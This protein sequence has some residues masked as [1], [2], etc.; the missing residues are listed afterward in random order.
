MNI[1]Q[2][3]QITPTTYFKNSQRN[4]T[5][6]N[7]KCNKNISIDEAVKLTTVDQKEVVE[8]IFKLVNKIKFLNKILG[9]NDKITKPVTVMLG[10]AKVSLM[11]D[12]SNTGKIKINLC[13]DTNAAI[14]E[15]VSPQRGYISVENPQTIR[16]EL[17]IILSTKDGRMRNGQLSVFNNFMTF[18]RNEKTGKRDLISD[19]LYFVPNMYECHNTRNYIQYTGF[20]RAANMV[21]AVFFNLFSNLTKVKPEINF[22]G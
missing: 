12:K 7:F 17:D 5:N 13:S 11:M 6:V 14:Y 9:K 10:D 21:S 2:Y 3:P 18:E 20:D 15:Y 4:H 1:T 22:L 16:Q 19:G 8:N